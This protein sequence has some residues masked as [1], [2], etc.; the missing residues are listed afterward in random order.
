MKRYKLI[1]AMG[2][3]ALASAAALTAQGDTSQEAKNQ[4]LVMNWYQEVVANGHVELAPK[5]MADDYMEHNPNYPGGRVE[6]VKY[7]GR[8]P[9]KPIQAALPTKPDRVFAKGDY[10][11]IVWELGDTD[12]KGKAY[13]Y[14]TYDVVRVANGKI[15]EHWDSAGKD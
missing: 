10:V 15:A 5:Y 12:A 1:L 14:N 2:A 7:F 11:V 3:F 6:F 13:K 4:K 9:A 8:T